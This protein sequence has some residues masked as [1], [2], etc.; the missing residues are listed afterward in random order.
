MA[1]AD[2]GMPSYYRLHLDTWEAVNATLPPIQA[3]KVLYAIERLFFEGV[4]PEEGSLPRAAQG[5]FDIQRQLI[6]GYRRNAVNGSRNRK[7]TQKPDQKTTQKTTQKPMQVSTQES[8]QKPT[9]ETEGLNTHLPA[10]TQKV[11]YKHSGKGACKHS[12]KGASDNNKQETINSTVAD[13]LLPSAERSVGVS[14]PLK[15]NPKTLR[16]DTGTESP[17]AEAGAGQGR[18]AP[19]LPSWA[20]L[21]GG[22]AP[23]TEPPTEADEARYSALLRKVEDH[24]AQGGAYDEALTPQE[25]AEF[26][27][28]TARRRAHAQAK[29][30]GGD[31]QQEGIHQ[32]Q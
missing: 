29:W 4:E 10:E 13:A 1:D 32:R 20:E 8:T 22:A 14:Q 15:Q 7:P 31:G 16:V 25:R 27:E 18:P 26:Q 17:R 28:I 5:L 11:G 3:A 12:G 23:E 24:V 21:M 9:Q 19:A 6:L 2:D 30:G